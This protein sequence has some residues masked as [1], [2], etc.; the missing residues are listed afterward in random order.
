MK[1][2]ITQLVPTASAAAAVLFGFSAC[3]EPPADTKQPAPDEPPSPA[4]AAAAEAPS[5]LTL[6]PGESLHAGSLYDIES[7]WRNTSGE[8]LQLSDLGGKVRVLAMGYS[9]CQYAC[10]RLVGDMRTMQQ[11]LAADA[12]L[13]GQVGFVFVSIDPK[14]DTPEKLKA[15]AERNDFDVSD[16]WLML[17]GDEDSVLELAVALG[18]K[19]RKTDNTD[20]AHSNIITVLDTT[21]HIVHQQFGL[22]TD[23]EKTLAAI[24]AAG[25]AP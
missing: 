8:T 16:D 14:N 4:P 9:S 20:F 19:Y 13:P 21:G 10:P 25:T 22:G 11:Q 23:S 24:H 15:Y 5:P 17:T 2:S 6:P 12:T 18:M 7:S 1:I 3:S